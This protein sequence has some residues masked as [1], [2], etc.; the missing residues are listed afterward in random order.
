MDII[1]KLNKLRLERN[2]SVY[3]LAELSGI[4][5]STLANTFSRGTI[6]SIQN[7]ELICEALGL[8][9]AQFFAENEREALLSDEEFRMY[10]NYKKLPEKIRQSLNEIINSIAE[11]KER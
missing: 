8:T 5:Q 9:M 2:M 3:R 4:N 11:N 1:K 6:P 10:E 7:L